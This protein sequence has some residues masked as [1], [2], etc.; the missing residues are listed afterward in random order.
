QW[1]LTP[2]ADGTPVSI[3]FHPSNCRYCFRI[4]RQHKSNGVYWTVHFKTMSIYQ[5][6]FDP[7]CAGFESNHFPI[8]PSLQEK[9]RHQVAALGS[10]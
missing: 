9:L 8:P 3:T 2:G 4:S 10:R 5:R 7:D 6:C 1:L